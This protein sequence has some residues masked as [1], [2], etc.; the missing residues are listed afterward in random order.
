MAGSLYQLYIE[1]Y[2]FP[3]VDTLKNHAALNI[4]VTG[5]SSL[6]EFPDL[7]DVSSHLEE[8]HLT[9]STISSVDYMPKMMK[10]KT[11]VL[12]NN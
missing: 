4:F 3:K 6:V 10:L 8:F 1:H 2:N 12:S 5:G 7:S 9:H 11:L